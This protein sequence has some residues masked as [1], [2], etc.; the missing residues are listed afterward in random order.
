MKYRRA[1]VEGGTY[2]FTVVM[3]SRQRIL[4][5]STARPLLRMAFK[6][7]RPSGRSGDLPEIWTARVG[8]VLS[9]LAGGMKGRVVTMRSGAPTGWAEAEFVV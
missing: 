5:W 2:F 4:T 6:E 7:V 1:R 9:V 3:R 8:A